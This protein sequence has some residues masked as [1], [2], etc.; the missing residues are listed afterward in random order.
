M[1]NKNDN[2]KELEEYTEKTVYKRRALPVYLTAA[3]AIVLTKILP[4]CELWGL[5]LYLCGTVALWL[6]FEKTV[7]KKKHVI[8]VP[9]LPK[10]TGDSAADAVIR[11]GR[12]YIAKMRAANDAIADP[13]ISEKIDRVAAICDKIFAHISENPQ[14]IP[15]IRRFMNYYLPTITKLL[16]SYNVFEKQEITEGNISRSMA[17]INRIMDVVEVAFKKQLDN[18]FSSEALDISA[19]VTVL[20]SLLNQ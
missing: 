6:F 5:I 4:L 19:D 10:T 20:E 2:K 14:K 11:E 3:S 8:K 7:K 17:E 18:L 13:E 16:E 15:Q 12:E 1:K 9:A